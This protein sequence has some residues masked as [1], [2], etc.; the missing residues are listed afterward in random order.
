MSGKDSA[1]PVPDQRTSPAGSCA[2]AAHPLID[3]VRIARA[4]LDDARANFADLAYL[5]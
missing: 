5:R 1:G 2:L 4:L 3:S